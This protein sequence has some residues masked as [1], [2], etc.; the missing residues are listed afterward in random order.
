MQ[1]N[2]TLL[3]RAPVAGDTIIKSNVAA[4]AVVVVVLYRFFS[5]RERSSSLFLSPSAAA[6]SRENFFRSTSNASQCI[7]IQL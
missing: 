3:L 1:H 7:V 4:A 5:T 2:C 6:R